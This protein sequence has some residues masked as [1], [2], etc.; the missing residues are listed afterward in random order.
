MMTRRNFSGR[1][2]PNTGDEL[3]FRECN[4][5]QP[6]PRDVGGLKRGIILWPGDGRPRTFVDC[7]LCN[8]EPPAGSTITGGLSVV[9]AFRVLQTSENVTLDGVVVGAIQ[10]WADIIY[11]RQLSGGVYEYKPTPELITVE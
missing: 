8:A 4:F 11:G 1:V 7:N 10:T 9:K 3:E 2:P 6:M 5:S